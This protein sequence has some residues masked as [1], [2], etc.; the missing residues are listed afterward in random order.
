M[1][2]SFSIKK[3]LLDLKQSR[4]FISGFLIILS[5]AAF[6]FYKTG[7][8]QDFELRFSHLKVKF[9]D[10]FFAEQGDL[11]LV[12][13]DEQSIDA[14][15]PKRNVE[16]SGKKNN[17]SFA[18]LTQVT[19]RILGLQPKTLTVFLP[20]Q[21]FVP[22]DNNRADFF[23]LLKTNPQLHVVTFDNP[24][25][26]FSQEIA[27]RIWSGDLHPIIQNKPQNH[28]RFPLLSKNTS[29]MEF[30]STGLPISV[31]QKSLNNIAAIDGCCSYLRGEVA[32]F[33]PKMSLHFPK[34]SLQDLLQ[35]QVAP[36][37]TIGGKHLLLGYSAYRHYTFRYNHATRVNVVQDSIFGSLEE[38]TSLMEAHAR[39]AWSVVADKWLRKPS[40]LLL[41]VISLI[42]AL[43][44]FYFSLSFD[45]LKLMALSLIVFL[46][47]FLVSAFFYIHQ[48]IDLPII[49]A[50]FW[51]SS[52]S[53]L[54]LHFRFRSRQKDYVK[55][56]SFSTAIQ[57]VY[58]IQN[59][60]FESLSSQLSGINQN[61]Y[62]DIDSLGYGKDDAATSGYVKDFL[63][64]SDQLE[65]YLQSILKL[66]E[67]ESSKLKNVHE[68]EY[69]ELA[70]FVDKIF[71]GLS[72]NLNKKNVRFEN[73][74]PSQNVLANQTILTQI[75]INIASNASKYVDK[76][77]LIKAHYHKN[78]GNHVIEIWNS[79]SVIPA[80][81]LENIFEKYYRVKNDTV[82]QE[83]G[84]GL[85]LFLSRF[86]ASLIGAKIYVDSEP[87]KGTAFMVE[88]P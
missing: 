33:K 77:G 5:F 81:E 75:V 78:Q 54:G 10:T 35:Q 20:T 66:N 22:N 34:I 87:G 1:L 55:E 71:K 31:D 3:M 44:V 50:I 21:V 70:S 38:G 28:Y 26:K 18:D 9:A 51:S 52:F 19:Q 68:K 76:D 43:L 14:F 4:F 58:E 47:L 32:Y 13:I 59:K 61:I 83:E 69:I 12:E 82:Y 46:F 40:F 7:L 41:F 8:R 80:A 62:R 27:S 49:D 29:H 57:S 42:S 88:W 11:V 72:I 56:K 48:S 39:S 17:L 53:F 84:T 45:A 24:Y 64:S 37:T 60:F 65:Q 15:H 63:S 6:L 25:E 67:L 36:S 73:H 85:G 16:K 86:L 30:V 23:D 74:I 79:G 2:L